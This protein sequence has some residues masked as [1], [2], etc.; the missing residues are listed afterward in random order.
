MHVSEESDSG[1]V[2]MNHS[3]KGGPPPAESEE[4]RPLVKENTHAVDRQPAFLRRCRLAKWRR[5]APLHAPS[6][7]VTYLRAAFPVAFE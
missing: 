3:N 6:Y 7:Q 5:K 2:P 1:V 4:G